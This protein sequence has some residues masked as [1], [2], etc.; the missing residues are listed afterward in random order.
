VA[1]GFQRRFAKEF[2]VAPGAVRLDHVV[3]NH[4]TRERDMHVTSADGTTRDVLEN[5]L[6]GATLGRTADTVHMHP[7][8]L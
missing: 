6:S 2:R 3:L 1:I 4:L 5:L 7:D 8:L